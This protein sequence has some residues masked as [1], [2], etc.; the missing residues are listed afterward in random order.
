MNHPVPVSPEFERLLFLCRIVR[1]E[2]LHLN[3][4]TS[5]LFANA[6]ETSAEEV[7][8]W[9]AEPE[10]SERLDAF[11]ARFSR[12]QDTVGDK[13]LPPLLLQ[14]GERPAAA[15]DNLTRAERLGWM[16]SAEDWM[17]CRTL[18]NQ[19]IHE[20]IE[21]IHVL[22]HALNAGKNFVP[23]MG[24]TSFRIICEVER[25]LPSSLLTPD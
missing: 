17:A 22:T 3:E 6:A 21:D 15:I 19:M 4:T 12:L 24:K 7:R 16:D 25:R 5:R 11:V 2:V 14:L 1:K 8:R 9:L 18:R 23:E 20:Y 13:L 10:L